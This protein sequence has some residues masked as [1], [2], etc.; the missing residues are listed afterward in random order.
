MDALGGCSTRDMAIIDLVSDGSAIIMGHEPPC[1]TD[2][3][4]TFSVA[5]W[6][7][8]NGRKGGF[9][10]YLRAME[11]LDIDIGILQETKLRKGIYTRRY[12]NYSVIVTD[13]DSNSHGGVAL[14]WR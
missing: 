12:G 4:G 8:R 13:A 5:S 9:E 1:Q 11:S 10:K 7:I 6:K 14:F 3:R 2:G